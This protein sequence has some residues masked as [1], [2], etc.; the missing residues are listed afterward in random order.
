MVEGAL[1][2]V[3]ASFCRKD[4]LF[5]SRFYFKVNSFYFT[6][7]WCKHD[8][9]ET[10]HL[11]HFYVP[12]V[13]LI[14]S[15]LVCTFQVLFFDDVSKRTE[16]VRHLRLE[17]ADIGQEIRV[18]EMSEKELLKE[19]LTKQERAQIVETFIRHAFSKVQSASGRLPHLLLSES[20]SCFKRRH[21]NVLISCLRSG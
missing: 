9:A 12:P 6:V 8:S 13:L 15:F 20:R 19:A 11:H 5:L 1:C 14:F 16:F 2:C 3:C 10:P 7:H 18:K 17:V 4:S 21:R